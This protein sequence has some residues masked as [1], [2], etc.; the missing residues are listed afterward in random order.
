[1]ASWISAGMFGSAAPAK[2]KAPED[3]EP[4]V[5]SRDDVS[6]YNEDNILPQSPETLSEIRKWL[7]PTSYD[8]KS[9]EFKKHLSSHVAG[10]G[11]WLLS[12]DTYR[13]WHDS[14]QN[15]LLW[16]RGIPGSGKS[17]FAAT[18]VHSLAQES[19]LVLY[20]F[21]RQIID[22]NHS[23][24]AALRDWLAQILNY[25]PPLQLKLKELL[26][27]KRSLESL[28]FSDIWSYLRTALSH[29]PKAYCVV[30]ALDEMDQ[31]EHADQFLQSLAT[32]SQWRPSE[33]KVIITSRPVP[34][35]ERPLRMAKA[36]NIRLEEDLVDIDI[37][38][39]VQSRL[40]TSSIPK[41]EHV[42]IQKA[43]P[44]RANGL[45]LYAKLAID[46]F[47][48][49]GANIQEVLRELPADLNVMY[50]DLLR[51]HAERSGVPNDTQL[52]IL[53][54]VT[55]AS[56]PL[57]LLEIA[58]MLSVTTQSED[59]PSLRE[60]KDLVRA[61]C[62]PLLEI[63]PN[64]TICVVHHSLTEFL[65]GSTR[66]PDAQ[67]YPI[68][69]FGSTH[70]S[71]AICCLSYLQSGCLDEVQVRLRSFN[72]D[73]YERNS[74]DM[75]QRWLST[76]FL[77]Y[78]LSN[79]YIHVRKAASVGFDQTQVNNMLDSFLTG[80][81]LSKWAYL[82]GLLTRASETTPFLTSIILGLTEYT[83]RLLKQPGAYQT[84]KDKE[85]ASSLPL[86]AS[87]G[88]EDL[89]KLLM[90][91][92]KNLDA[93]DRRGYTALHYAAMHNHKGIAVK[94][95][96]AGADPLAKKAE[97]EGTFHIPGGETRSNAFDY[98]CNYG[99]EEVAIVFLP[100]F[101][102]SKM[103]NYAF[104]CAVSR[105]RAVLLEKIL[106]NPLVNVN[107]QR[108]YCGV[109][110]LF[111]ACS[112]QNP[113]MVK[114]L[115]EAG[116]DP[117]IL[118]RD[119]NQDSDVP[120][121]QTAL[122]D[123]VSGKRVKNETDTQAAVE[124]FELL[125]RAGVN[126]HQLDFDGCTALH[127]ATDPVLVRLL[128]DAG[129]D[130]NAVNRFG[131]TLLHLSENHDI[132]QL[133]L[134]HANADTT[135]KAKPGGC[136]PLLSALEKGIIDKALQ[137]VEFGA[138]LL[139]TD[140]KGNGAIHYVLRNRQF[141]TEQRNLL[142]RLVASG[143]DINLRNNSGQTLLH[144]LGQGVNSM[145]PRSKL[146][147]VDQHILADLIQLGADLE[148][149]D[150]EG[151]TPLYKMIRASSDSLA[152]R[153]ACQTM[154]AA[155]AL[156]NTT[157]S[158]GQTLLHAYVSGD[159]S[160]VD[161][162]K[163]LVSH[164]VDPL[165]TD[166]EG[167]TLWHVA[168]PR[169]CKYSFGK[170]THPPTLFEKFIDM[171][172]SP[173]QPNY[174]GRTPLHVVSSFRPGYFSLHNRSTDRDEVTVFNYVLALQQNVDY[175]DNRGVTALHLAATFSEWQTWRLLQ[176]GADPFNATSESLTALHLAAR[177]GQS[178]IVGMLLEA[179]KMQSD[180][181]NFI[182]TINVRDASGKTPLY[183]ACASGRVQI[184]K[185]LI[186]A[187]AEVWVDQ[188]EGSAWEGCAHFEDKQ[189]RLVRREYNSGPDCGSVTI[190]DRSPPKLTQ[191]EGWAFGTTA[192]YSEGLHEIIKVLMHFKSG[193]AEIIDQA[194][195]HAA[196]ENFHFTVE[197][198]LNARAA[199]Q[200]VEP[201][202]NN[203]PAVASCLAL[204]EKLRDSP[205][206]TKPARPLDALRAQALLEIRTPEVAAEKWMKMDCLKV[207][208]KA[209]TVLHR[210]VSSGDDIN[211]A[212]LAT[213]EVA[214]KFEQQDWCS[215]YDRGNYRV[216][217]LLIEACDREEPNMDVIRV[218]VESVGVNLNSRRRLGGFSI[219]EGALH[220]LV[221]GGFWWQTSV[222]LPYLVQKGAD[223]EI[224]DGN[225]LTPLNAALERVGSITFNRRLVEK[226]IELGA[227]VNSVDDKGKSCLSRVA[228][229]TKLTKFLLQ[230]GAI[231][232]SSALIAAIDNKDPGLLEALLSTGADP[233]VQQTIEQKQGNNFFGG[234]NADHDI[235]EKMARILLRY[236][237][238]PN[239]QYAAEFGKK[240]VIS[241]ISSLGR[242]GWL[243]SECPSLDL[244][245]RDGSGKTL[246]L[247]ICGTKI[248]AF[249]RRSEI[250]NDADDFILSTLQ[251]LI[252][253]GADVRVRDYSGENALHHLLSPGNHSIAKPVKWFATHAP[254]LVN[255]VCDNG[256]APLHLAILRLGSET[257]AP[258]DEIEVLLDSGADPQLRDGEGNTT[259]HLLLTSQWKASIDGTVG[260]NR[261]KL[262][263]RLVA[264]G[265]DVNARNSKGETPAFAFFRH[266][267][268]Q[269]VAQ[270]FD[271]S[272]KPLFDFGP[273]SKSEEARRN[274]IN[275]GLEAP[276]F[277]FLEQSGVDFKA[278]NN[279][280][281]TLLHIVA[282]DKS[283]SRPVPKKR[284]KRF[285]FLMRKGVDVAAEDNNQRTALDVAAAL[286]NKAILELFEKKP[287][288]VSEDQVQKS[289]V[290]APVRL[291]G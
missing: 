257:S 78:A 279:T 65:N 203:D 129:A 237:A 61:A 212:R 278:V 70:N 191:N 290:F 231:V 268:F 280:G 34:S 114:L 163:F 11:Q 252:N 246:L 209:E 131:E 226:L 179:L 152:Q 266:G 271:P 7:Q 177:Y 149:K 221:R 218:L 47:L 275:D 241:H 124:C 85:I 174:I 205:S 27:E 84:D 277:Q 160:D 173:E 112:T 210:L 291:F 123:L 103:I 145:F 159:G 83:K 4:V 139:E 215:Q 258:L 87:H 287:T 197:C 109:T 29:L 189:N 76:P 243:F 102:T 167:N 281:E 20:F 272:T 53:Q 140:D 134:E 286:N 23:P 198:L 153:E 151:Q 193:K 52:L 77:R 199:F 99:H 169:Y 44:G 111:V 105:N 2:S 207:D 36:L 59:K 259:L 66:E 125:I 234:D 93:V 283:G 107:S 120:K 32:L 162:V 170:S 260:G 168:L 117:N 113:Q 184:V 161:F 98:A 71:L 33:F 269:Y 17:V 165:Q 38:S 230:N 63:M 141:S 180:T 50:N 82:S 92:S 42:A 143:A 130:P 60:T 238:D 138:D 89:V 100:Y 90:Q 91:H 81:T 244:E 75:N 80:E 182:R 57:R 74:M 251:I 289:P 195:T 176:T 222:A 106:E 15:G 108:H 264:T 204:I 187:G 216:Q 219:G 202:R 118:R 68:L 256:I 285:Q 135:L 14:Y 156:L 186:Q 10:T 224:R 26:K 13:E 175:A 133:L 127:L 22:A 41:E 115:L 248:S 64:E 255:S 213:L 192:L 220:I 126:I 73:E 178:N 208:E 282:A 245:L 188:Y 24:T 35:V 54:W 164:G 43:V 3:D 229:D 8:D 253:R 30:D 232:S 206:E 37:A 94:L 270:H 48:R 96:E 158:K 56:R 119:G 155:G 262:F 121:G 172:V 45:F 128:L 6:D 18:L 146:E 201:Y 240:S 171:G 157:D 39:Y 190:T 233:N 274:L 214:Q 250:P 97:A 122:F 46:A 284:E 62:G 154:M 132:I 51:Q 9:S 137:L 88:Y 236:G 110:A 150:N 254:E 31:G 242:I 136:T 16:I 276:F 144:L 200:F 148:L 249:G 1:M 217:P 194:I 116:A 196:Q 5:L 142:H 101:K 265:V 55:H 58:E 228:G 239:A 273:S 49:P 223:I 263:E 261:R 79:W 104:H 95:L 166:N 183:Y 19:V 25:S 235:Y 40:S 72:S 225:G 12:S 247:E 28:S 147:S 185:L 181:G 69:D 227:D 67:G 211:L 267:G 288:A 21:F 86:A